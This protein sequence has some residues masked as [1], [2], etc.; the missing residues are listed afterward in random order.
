MQRMFYKYSSTHFLKNVM[1]NCETRKGYT[2]YICLILLDIEGL[3]LSSEACL[4]C[5]SQFAKSLRPIGN[6]IWKHEKSV[7]S[8]VI[9]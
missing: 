5:W 2:N 1:Y 3:V 7:N 8:F 4:I 6:V 9:Q